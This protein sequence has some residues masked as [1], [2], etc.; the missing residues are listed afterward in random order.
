MSTL[1]TGY[2]R[3]GQPFSRG[4]HL[5]GTLVL[6]DMRQTL[7]TR[8]RTM[9]QRVNHSNNKL[10]RHNCGHSDVTLMTSIKCT[11]YKLQGC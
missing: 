6:R 7:R 1:W 3:G 10:S 2:H 9:R 11:L 8:L 4:H 5:V